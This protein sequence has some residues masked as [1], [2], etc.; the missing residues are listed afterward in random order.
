MKTI[1]LSAVAFSCLLFASSAFAE[2]LSFLEAKKDGVGADGLR[3]ASALAVSPDGLN[4][5]A[6]GELDDAVSVFSRDPSTGLLTY[7]EM[8]KDNVAGVDGLNAVDTIHVVGGGNHVYTGSVGDDAIAIFSRDVGDGGRLSFSHDVRNGDILGCSSNAVVQ[9]LVNVRSVTSDLGGLFVYAAAYASDSIVVFQ[10]DAWFGDLCYV[11]TT[12]NGVGGVT[13]LNGVSALAVS[14]DGSHLYAAGYLDDSVAVFSIDSLTGALTFVT[15]Y[16]SGVGGVTGLNGA[17]SI[18]VSWDGSNVYAGGFLD[19]SIVVFDRDPGTGLLAQVASY[20][21]G[22]G[23]IDGLNAVHSLAMGTFDDHLY[24]AAYSD[25]SVTV[26]E[27]DAATGLLTLEQ[28]LTDGA[29]GG[30]E[31]ARAQGV[32]PTWDGGHVYAVGYTDHALSAFQ[33]LPFGHESSLRFG[34]VNAETQVR[35]AT[36]SNGNTIVAGTFSG[37]M[38]VGTG[39]AALT[40]AGG[41]DAFVVK[42]SP[43]GA[44]LWSL[45]LGGA[46]N[47]TAAAVAVDGAN[48]IV[49]TGEMGG[50]VDFGGGPVTG[51]GYVVKLG[52][53]ANPLWSKGFPSIQPGAWTSPRD[54]AANASGTIVLGGMQSGPVDYGAGNVLSTTLGNLGPFVV[55]LAANGSFLWGH[56][57]ASSD[58]LEPEPVNG[59]AIDATGNVAVTGDHRFSL[60]M[61]CSTTATSPYSD[62]FVMKLTPTGT[63]AWS[64]VFGATDGLVFDR[65]RDVAFGAAGAVVAAGWLEGAGQIG[66]TALPAGGH[67]VVS[68]TSAGAVSWVRPVGTAQIGGIATD[69]SGNVL[70]GGHFSGTTS[71]G[72]SPLS[73]AGNTDV[74]FARYSATNAHQVSIRHGNSLAQLTEAVVAAPDGDAIFVGRFEGALSFGGPTLTSAGASDLFMARY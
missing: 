59:V 67:F 58:T 51:T 38:T 31:L 46:G 1:I 44:V 55:S 40:S 72:G 57:G 49:V 54:V 35:A 36:D 30:N 14:P 26:F 66:S 73:S 61:G 33:I 10:R 2:G 45:R 13:G 62:M 16:K 11:E 47:D 27:R 60:T 24:A 37:S 29:A 39:A 32:A 23:G 9:G 53:A 52:P 42:L 64:A 43:A 41:T 71:V 56:G 8:E 34:G 18:T 68:L 28:V 70:V 17:R 19:D 48:N 15:S 65:G 25:N 20:K 6:V 69:S 21:D 12:K 7:L 22:V 63:C 4:V 50:T 3:G 5:Y 74:F